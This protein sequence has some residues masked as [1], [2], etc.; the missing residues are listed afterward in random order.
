ME[1]LLT[2]KTNVDTP[3]SLLFSFLRFFFFFPRNLKRTSDRGHTAV[4]SLPLPDFVFLV[5]CRTSRVVVRAFHR[6]SSE[7]SFSP[8]PSLCLADKCAAAVNLFICLPLLL[9]RSPA[10]TTAA[11][12][13]CLTTDS[14][15][16]Q[17]QLSSFSFVH[18]PQSNLYPVCVLS[19]SSADTPRSL[20]VNHFQTSFFWRFV[21]HLFFIPLLLARSLPCYYY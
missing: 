17:K 2:K 12:V 18:A 13:Q 15:V 6:A 1:S 3:V 9:A 5:L 4:F 10:T 19:H 20:F 7:K 16:T 11:V 14:P 8:S 21:E